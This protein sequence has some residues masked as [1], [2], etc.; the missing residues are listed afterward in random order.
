MNAPPR[1]RR[2]WR[3]RRGDTRAD[4]VINTASPGAPPG[5]DGDPKHVIPDPCL[6]VAGA[7]DGRAAG[8][9]GN[10]AGALRCMERRA[11]ARSPSLTHSAIRTADCTARSRTRTRLDKLLLFIITAQLFLFS[12]FLFFP[13]R[14]VTSNLVAFARSIFRASS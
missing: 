11:C 13:R 1:R 14:A 7:F 4:K 8:E 6:A 3:R 5:N 9:K 12:P 2:G 10:P